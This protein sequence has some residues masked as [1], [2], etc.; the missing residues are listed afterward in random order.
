MGHLLSIV[1][2]SDRN[3]MTLRNI[4]IVFSPTLEIPFGI[5]SIL[6]SEFSNVFVD[7]KVDCGARRN[8]EDTNPQSEPNSVS[9][10]TLKRHLFE[11]KANTSKMSTSQEIPLEKFPYDFI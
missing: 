11:Q 2:N 7:R 5:F 9:E 1:Q 10:S 4:S 3:K 8:N 6:V